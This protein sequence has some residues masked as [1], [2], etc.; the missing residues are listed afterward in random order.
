MCVY[1]RNLTPCFTIFSGDSFFDGDDNVGGLDGDEVRVGNAAAGGSRDNVVARER[2]VSL[3]LI[4]NLREHLLAAPSEY[5]YFDTGKL[6]SWAGPQHWKF[7]PM[8]NVAAATLKNALAASGGA[9]AQQQKGGKN[10]KK[11]TIEEYEF[12]EMFAQCELTVLLD[13]VEK[14]MK[15]PKKAVGLQVWPLLLTF[16]SVCFSWFPIDFSEG[17]INDPSP[18]RTL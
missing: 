4:D 15:I 13:A 10:K 8:R 7:K 1:F 6:G 17:L 5:S 18:G 2:G 9:D 16:F 14:A 3:A 12:D 11:A